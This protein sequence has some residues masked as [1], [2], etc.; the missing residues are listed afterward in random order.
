MD[1]AGFGNRSQKAWQHHRD[2]LK[3]SLIAD[4]A[5]L[6]W[7]WKGL[8]RLADHDQRTLAQLGRH[9]APGRRW[10]RSSPLVLKPREPNLQAAIDPFPPAPEHRRAKGAALFGPYNPGGARTVKPDPG[11]SR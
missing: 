10:K 5:A 1:Q 6:A 4:A 2:P 11:G 9:G 8:H 7:S 3:R